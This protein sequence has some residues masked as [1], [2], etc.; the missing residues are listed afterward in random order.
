MTTVAPNDTVTTGSGVL[1]DH[2]TYVP[3]LHPWFHTLCDRLLQALPGVY[4]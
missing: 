4:H 2:P 3:V 1:L